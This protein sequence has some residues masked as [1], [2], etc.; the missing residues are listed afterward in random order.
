MAGALQQAAV[1]LPQRLF[2]A[3]RVSTM[4]W[5]RSRRPVLRLGSHTVVVSRRADVLDVLEDPLTFPP[6]YAHGIASG[7]VLGATGED[8]TRHRSALRHVL[9]V[10]DLE[11]LERRAAELATASLGTAGP[12]D[13]AVG[14]ELVRP[15]MITTMREYLGITGSDDA[16]MT[17]WSRAIFQDIFLSRGLPVI[18][19]RGL[20]AAEEFRSVAR[21]CTAEHLASAEQRPV[22]VA[23]RLL[24]LQRTSPEESLDEA[25]VVDTLVGL[26]IGWFWHGTKAALLCVDGL[27]DDDEAMLAASTAAAAGDLDQLRRVLLEVLRF[28]PVQVGLPR[29]C[30]RDT[31]LAEGTPH[32]TEVPAG[33]YVLAGTHAAM[34]DDAVVPDPGRFDATRPIQ[35]YVVFGHGPHK[36]LGEAIMLRQLPAMLQPLLARG[37]LTRVGGRRGRLRWVGPH[38]DD[39]RVRYAG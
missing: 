21:R 8:L 26:A 24:S 33:S 28:R 3:N 35:Q 30:A 4:S 20:A 34:W 13:L 7:F 11:Q 39:L 29:T 10:E 25:E 17:A 16:T 37:G 23:G 18:T 36:C 19:E 2:D 14:S 15:V 38:P 31:T 12:D 1:T 6:P 5:L 27:L 22:D 32:E 9:R